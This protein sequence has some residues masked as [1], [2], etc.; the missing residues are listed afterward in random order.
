MKLVVLV[1]HPIQHFCPQ[2]R[3][4]AERSDV[5][6]TVVFGSL[7]GAEPYH[8]AGFGRQV[9]WGAGLLEGFDWRIAPNNRAVASALDDLAPDHLVIY[10]YAEP[11]SRAAWRWAWRRDVSI[12]YVADSEDRHD[13][14]KGLREPLKALVIRRLFRRVSTFLSVGDANEEYYLARGVPQDRIVRM[15]FPI[16]P[17]ML[18]RDE[19]QT[20]LRAELGVH[21]E[22]LVV[23]NVG[24]FET[25]KRQRDL[26]E[27]ARRFTPRDLHLLMAGSGDELEACRELA[28]DAPNITFLG[29]VPPG[30]LVQLYRGSDVYAHVSSYDPHPLAVSEA[31]ASGCALVVADTTGSWGTH[32]DVAP[33][34]T[35][36]VVRCGQ[37]DELAA[38]LGALAANRPWAAAMGTAARARAERFQRRSHGG[39]IDD[40]ARRG[41]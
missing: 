10:G 17:A 21:P 19:A 18:G 35:G 41:Q 30:G 8:D 40:L 13:A 24:K 22:A 37:I 15:H 3:S 33:Y 2:Y 31:A 29:F 16:S 4:L 26:V 32:D 9:S 39:F 5:D 20:E 6:L 12:A 14:A 34:E 36:L 28:A 23:L 38:A 27:T 25:R 1:S 7:K 11:I